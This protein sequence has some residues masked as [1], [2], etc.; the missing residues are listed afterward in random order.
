MTHKAWRLMFPAVVEPG[1]LCVVDLCVARRG[2]ASL[3]EHRM[4]VTTHRIRLFA[5]G[6]AIPG[7]LWIGLDAA[8]LNGMT[9]RWLAV[10]RLA[11]AIVLLGLAHL[12]PRLRAPRAVL[13][14][15]AALLACPL[16][17]GLVAQHLLGSPSGGGLAEV[18]QRLYAALPFI[19]LTG[20]GMFPLLLVEGLAPA[21]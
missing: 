5:I 4:A 14:S 3:T 20:R 12:A 15:L 6:F 11:A 13:G 16:A 8:T 19:V 1:G 2:A 9:W 10:T 7:L 21:A 18:N 17:I